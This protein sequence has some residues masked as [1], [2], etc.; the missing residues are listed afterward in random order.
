MNLI[1]KNMDK[2]DYEN[3]SKIALLIEALKLS[4]WD[5]FKYFIETLEKH[6]KDNYK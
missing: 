3:I 6:I 5:D 2:K 4:L 1:I